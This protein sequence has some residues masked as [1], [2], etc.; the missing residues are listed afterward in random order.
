MTVRSLVFYVGFLVFLNL[1]PAHV[2][3]YREA[4]LV[5][6]IDAAED[7]DDVCDLCEPAAV[8]APRL[9]VSG[10]R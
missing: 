4:D 6:R 8:F 10:Q 3:E 5:V 1:C 7:T 9:S 2:T